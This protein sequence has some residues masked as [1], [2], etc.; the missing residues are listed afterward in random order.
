[1]AMGH[2]LG[3]M[4]WD[5]MS[6]TIP[7][8]R[9]WPFT[10]MVS[11]LEDMG[12][13][14]GRLLTRN[15][16][17]EW[18]YGDAEEMVPIFD[19]LRGFE[20]GAR[21]IGSEEFGLLLAKRF[22]VSE[23][24]SYGAAITASKTVFEAMR[25]ACQ[26]ASKEATTA[27]YWLIPQSDGYNFCRKQLFVTPETDHGL[28]QLEQY[29]LELMVNIVRLGAGP[30]WQPTTVFLSTLRNRFPT[31]QRQFNPEATRYESPHSAIFVPAAVLG[32]PIRKKAPDS[33]FC[34]MSMLEASRVD[35]D[36]CDAVME[37][38][39]SSLL[40]DSR[41]L[42]TLATVAEA[43]GMSKRTLQRRLAQKGSSVHRLYDEV[44]YR[45]AM[46]LID[47]PAIKIADIAASTGYEHSQHFINAFRRWTGLTPGQYRKTA[48]VETGH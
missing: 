15:N 5:R 40:I 19:F 39:R 37:F 45:K 48:T 2:A 11:S 26:L 29:S 13:N 27:R 4:G 43:A 6:S 16:I 36:I 20:C 1:M 30:D 21:A 33:R 24:G 46:E 14:S 38:L 23:F 25:T 22:G 18:Q 28:R 10:H 3:P 42:T 44:K 17:P 7:L 31:K 34:D 35:E 9:R 41:N 47:D 8:I 12:I 32:L